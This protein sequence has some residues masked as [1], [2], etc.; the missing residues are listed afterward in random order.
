MNIT[1]EHR[2]PFW[3]ATAILAAVYFVP[4]IVTVVWQAL[5]P[6]S[7]TAR[8]LQF[9]QPARWQPARAAMAT[10]AGPPHGSNDGTAPAQPSHRLTMQDISGAWSYSVTVAPGVTASHRIDLVQ[11]GDSITGRSRREI[12]SSFETDYV[13]FAITGSSLESGKAF[14]F[15]E[16]QVIERNPPDRPW[17]AF[18]SM[19][20]VPTAPDTLAGTYEAPPCL[21]GS[22]LFRRTK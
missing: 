7:A 20:V 1:Q 4:S 19:T 14:T 11:K 17:C 8:E 16:G 18:R 13:V 15:Q 21:A 3:T 22:I 6:L 2:K 5:H 12:K 10:Q 9:Q